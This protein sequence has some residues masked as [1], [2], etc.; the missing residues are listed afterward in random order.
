MKLGPANSAPHRLVRAP[1]TA[2]SS[3]LDWVAMPTRRRVWRLV[4]HHE[5][6]D[7]AAKLAQERGRVAIGWGAIGDLQELAV[8]SAHEIGFLIRE[9]YPTLVN[10]G[11]GG[12]SLWNLYREMQP[13]DLVIVRGDSRRRLVMEI[14]GPYL[15]LDR[16]DRRLGDYQH[17]RA[18]RPRS[19]LN[20]NELWRRAG[21]KE[22]KGEN[23][24]WTLHLC[25]RRVEL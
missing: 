16:E 5:H 17:T 19:D 6:A 8:T 24:Y 1:S 20:P 4:G 11:L 15:Y 23:G 12:P 14:A 2:G 22:A 7:L 10:S 3:P 18:A 21:A 13:R 9:C 25:R